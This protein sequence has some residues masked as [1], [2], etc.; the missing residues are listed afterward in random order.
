[1]KPPDASRAATSAAVRSRIE[2]AGRGTAARRPARCG[3]ARHRAAERGRP[4]R[5]STMTERIVIKA[6]REKSLL[7]RH[8]WIFSGAIERVAGKPESGATVDVVDTRGGFLARAAYSPMSQI[9]ARVWSFDPAEPIDELFFKRRIER[10]VDARRRLGYLADDG[11]CRLVFS[12]SD[13]LPGVIV[14]RYT[15]HLVCQFLSAGA[16][17]WRETIVGELTDL[18]GPRAVH[19]RS[20]GAARRKE[21]LPSRRGTIA[22]AQGEDAV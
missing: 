9:R 10:A 12:E 11:A 5:T 22:A 8:P 3:F 13:G 6:G 19:E 2:R 15:D 20:E 1:M 21:G 14:D 18:L 7:R 4:R 16:E 17:R